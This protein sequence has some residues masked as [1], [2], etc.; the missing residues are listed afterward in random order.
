MLDLLN[1]SF[2][3][4]ICS[5]FPSFFP[6]PSLTFNFLA[7][8]GGRF[9]F[10]FQFFYWISFHFDN[11][12]LKFPNIHPCSLFFSYS[13]LLL[14]NEWTIILNLSENNRGIF[15]FPSFLWNIYFLWDLLFFSFLFW[16]LWICSLFSNAWWSMVVY[17][18]LRI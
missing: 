9:N 3:V 12:I 7:L 4:F 18:Y 13:I 1:W 14:L 15:I 10:I 11:P 2:I 16:S 17:S 5:L 8:S 6:P